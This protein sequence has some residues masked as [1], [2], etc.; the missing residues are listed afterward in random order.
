MSGFFAIED[1]VRFV[2]ARDQAHHLLKSAPNAHVTLV[3][4]RGMKIQSQDSVESFRHVLNNPKFAS[5][6]LAIVVAQSLARLQIK[7]AAGERDA[8]YFDSVEGAEA[9]LLAP[10]AAPAEAALESVGHA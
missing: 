8:R 10:D 2:A 7:R 4:I 5:R 3:D 1:I 6:R 9:W